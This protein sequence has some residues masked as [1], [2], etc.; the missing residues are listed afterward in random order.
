M[1]G[2]ARLVGYALNALRDGS[3]V[4][5]HRVVNAKGEISKR[6][7][8]GPMDIFQRLRLKREQVRFD[9]RGSIALDRFQWR[10][11]A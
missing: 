9:D 1:P 2:Q 11:K 7:D 10:P 8:G 3:A 4:P 5:W 6:S